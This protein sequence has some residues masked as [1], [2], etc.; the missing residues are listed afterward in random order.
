M[1]LHLGSDF[2]IKNTDIIAIFNVRGCKEDM[3]D[4]LVKSNKY[5][6]VDLSE[7]SEQ[8]SLVLT[9]KVIYISA[10]SALTLKKRAENVF[11]D[12]FYS[13]K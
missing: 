8:S 9:E 12:E 7:G 4:N 3:Y 13:N 11:I 5:E 10:I 2:V 6:V 1:Y